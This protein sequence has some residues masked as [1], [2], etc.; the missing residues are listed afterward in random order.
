MSPISGRVV[1]ALGGACG[2]L[3]A[4]PR[5]QPRVASRRSPLLWKGLVIG[6][7]WR[8]AELEKLSALPSER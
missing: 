4:L 3:G 2:L 7:C 6:S 8:E 5:L 1:W